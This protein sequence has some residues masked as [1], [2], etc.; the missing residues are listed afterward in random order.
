MKV[1]S[2]PQ[3]SQNMSVMECNNRQDSLGIPWC[4][5]HKS[6]DARISPI[7]FSLRRHRKAETKQWQPGTTTENCQR[8]NLQHGATQTS[9]SSVWQHCFVHWGSQEWKKRSKQKTQI[10]RL[11]CPQGKIHKTTVE[12]AQLNTDCATH[13]QERNTKEVTSRLM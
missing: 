10:Q 11:T 3:L 4:K 2:P 7:S 9:P 8:H 13:P 1:V 6:S 12:Q 5:N